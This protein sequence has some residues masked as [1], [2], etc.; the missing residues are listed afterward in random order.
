MSI[1][2][3]L[4]KYSL[5]FLSE[6]A[7]NDDSIIPM[8]TKDFISDSILVNTYRKEGA[9]DDVREKAIEEYGTGIVW[10]FGIPTIKKIFDKTIYKFLKL[11]PNFDIRNLKDNSYIQKTTK[12]LN[13]SSQEFLKHEKELFL[14]L[15]KEN[16]VLKNG[17]SNAS[18]YKWLFASKFVISTLLS[19]FA[20]SKIIKYKQKT[21]KEKIEKEYFQKNGSNILIKK[22]IKDESVYR[23]FKGN[24]NQKNNSPAF[25]GLGSVFLYNNIANTFILDGVIAGLRLKES[26]RGEKKEILLKEIFQVAF[27]YGLAKPIE[28]AFNKVAEKLKTPINLDPKVIF[29][30]DI[31]KKAQ[32]ALKIIKDN[33]LVLEMTVEKNGTKKVIKNLSKDAI[34]KLKQI[35]KQNP[36]NSLADILENNGVVNLIRDKNGM[37]HGISNLSYIDSKKLL[38][39]FSAIESL[40]DNISNISKIK[41]FKLFAIFGNIALAMVG[42]GIIQPKINI[43]MRKKLNNGDNRNQ[44]I[45]EQEKQMQKAIENI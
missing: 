22:D 7:N 18:L 37:K 27:V 41:P 40:S 1:N 6:I 12:E 21:T 45:I 17:I 15:N 9:K 43:W 16:S 25:K 35:S 4:S 5:K 26:R 14:T 34:D 11:D 23:A 8:A 2:T 19:A 20:L 10:I 36:D 38:K 33:N 44:A 28:L 24:K 31:S 3:N 32:D 30:K 29:D 13:K 42:M 39:S